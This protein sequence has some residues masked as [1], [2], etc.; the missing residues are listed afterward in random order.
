MSQNQNE[1][2][3]KPQRKKSAFQ[4]KLNLNQRK[5]WEEIVSAI[6]KKEV[7]VD[8]LDKIMVSLIDGTI[9]EIDIKELLSQGLSSIEVEELLNDKFYN[10]DDYIENVNFYVD[11][12]AVEES[13]QPATDKALKGL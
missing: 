1:P 10:L 11:V 9:V 7:P 4:K 2:P 5:M 12:D 3:K 6:D 13:I 8:V